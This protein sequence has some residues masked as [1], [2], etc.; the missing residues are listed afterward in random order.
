MEEA[1]EGIRKRSQERKESGHIGGVRE[2]FEIDYLLRVIDKLQA[3][4][5]KGKK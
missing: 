1:I 4:D 3:S 2:W 5:E